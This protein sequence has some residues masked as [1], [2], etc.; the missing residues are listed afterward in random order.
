MADE[1]KIVNMIYQS[2]VLSGVAIGYSVL[3]KRLL[4]I[5]MDPMDK[6]D[7]EDFVK[8]ASI[9]SLSNLTAEM[10]YER[11]LIPRDIMK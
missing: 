8:I 6:I 7:I 1:K 9:I 5:K 4:K 10:L 2:A 3:G 11:G